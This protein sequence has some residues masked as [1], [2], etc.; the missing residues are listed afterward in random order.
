[1]R[2]ARE[3]IRDRVLVPFD[4][5][6]RRSPTASF[7]AFE[8]LAKPAPYAARGVAVFCSQHRDGRWRD[9]SPGADTLPTI[10]CIHSARGRGSAPHARAQAPGIGRGAAFDRGASLRG[11]GGA[12]D[13][14]TGRRCPRRIEHVPQ[15]IA[16][17]AA[18]LAELERN[19]NGLTLS[20][21]STTASRAALPDANARDQAGRRPCHPARRGDPG[22]GGLPTAVPGPP[23]VQRIADTAAGVAEDLPSTARRWAV[24]RGNA[25][26]RASRTVEF[27]LRN[28][29]QARAGPARAKAN[30]AKN[31]PGQGGRQHADPRR[32][33]GRGRRY[34]YRL[35]ITAAAT[36]PTASERAAQ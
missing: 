7:V 27:V 31:G 4:Q 14:R 9:G 24:H 16:E 18:E 20:L 10:R 32:R 13:D 19:L 28:A 1:M 15:Q 3:R 25:Q 6:G 34:D 2:F 11:S 21:S 12:R 8:M 33:S 5:D 36:R 35:A 26:P 23:G 17:A 29:E 30:N 22:D